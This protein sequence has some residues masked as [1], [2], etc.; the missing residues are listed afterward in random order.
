MAEQNQLVSVSELGMLRIV[1]EHIKRNIGIFEDMN[2][3]TELCSRL[4]VPCRIYEDKVFADNSIRGKE[5]FVEHFEDRERI[6]SIEFDGDSKEYDMLVS[7]LGIIENEIFYTIKG[8]FMKEV[9]ESI[10]YNDTL[11]ENMA[12]MIEKLKYKLDLKCSYGIFV[13][14]EKKNTL[15]CKHADDVAMRKLS[16]HREDDT[17]ISRVYR[18]GQSVTAEN[19]GMS[20]EKEL[21]T[22]ELAPIIALPIRHREPVAVVVL[23]GYNLRKL[24]KWRFKLLKD[25]VSKFGLVLENIMAMDKL[26]GIA[27]HDGMLEIYTRKTI[28]SKIEGEMKRNKRVALLMIDLDHFKAYND[29]HGHVEGDKLLK[30]FASILRKVKRDRDVVGR[31][32][33]DEFVICSPENN[34]SGSRKLAERIVAECGK[35]FKEVTCSVGVYIWNGVETDIHTLFK[36]VD[37]K[38]YAAK[39]AGK[40]TVVI[41]ETQKDEGIRKIYA[42][43]VFVEFLRKKQD[44]RKR[45]GTPYAVLACK[46]DIYKVLA[47]VRDSDIV[48]DIDGKVGV[49]LVNTDKK[50]LEIV[51]NRF[52]EADIIID[53]KECY[54]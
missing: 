41:E 52:R 32:G 37:E 23:A 8:R 39:K 4:G 42:V 45:Y 3:F 43:D 36:M 38:L 2:G 16:P 54:A 17:I 26:R 9:Q 47:S 18:D 48:G 25:T 1:N 46:G 14:N 35:N 40:N 27:Q 33:G 6:G 53:K 21:E 29:K 49:I 11:A 34:A 50:G 19:F 10:S 5:I 20:I 22:E 13:L 44:E 24:N 31:Y 12:R 7:Q 15:E 28:E 30:K 51:E